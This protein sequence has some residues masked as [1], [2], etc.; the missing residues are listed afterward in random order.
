MLFMKSQSCWSRRIHWGSTLNVRVLA[1]VELCFHQLHKH[2]RCCYLFDI[3]LSTLGKIFS[4]RHFYF[5]QKKGFHISCKLS[6]METIC[7]KCQN[8][9][10]GKNKKTIISLSSAEFVH[11]IVGVKLLFISV[12]SIPY[13]EQGL[14]QR[15]CGSACL[16]FTLLSLVW[17]HVSQ[18]CGNLHFYL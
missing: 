13:P 12:K 15:C 6:P 16:F 4:R 3:T 17:R 7:M 9:F 10:S 14:N 8:L 11:S 2:I 18:L 1:F 5:S